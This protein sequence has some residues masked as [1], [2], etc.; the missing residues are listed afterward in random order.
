MAPG[1]VR[2]TDVLTIWNKTREKADRTRRLSKLNFRVGQHVRIS[3]EKVKLTKGVEQ[4]YTTEIFKVRKVVHRTPRPVFELEDLRGQEIEGQFYSEELVPVLIT[5]QTTYKTDKI[6]DKRVRRG[7]LEYLVRR[8]LQR[9]FRF[10]G[11]CQRYTVCLNRNMDGDNFYITL[12]SNASQ[13]IYPDNKIAAF[14]IQLAQPI[15]LDPSEICEVGLCELAYSA[16][17]QQLVDSNALVYCDVIAPQFIGASMIRY[18]RTF[19]TMPAKY[20]DKFLYENVYYV[21]VEKRT[22]R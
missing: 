3:K 20:G 2:D 19:E 1:S 17:Q 16:T 5:K 4:N 9:R 14:T 6:L 21:A 22:F 7:I 10:L 12:F 11:S 18:L 13:D 8:R 15:R